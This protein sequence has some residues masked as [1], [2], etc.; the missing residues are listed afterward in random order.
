VRTKEILSLLYR[1]FLLE[2]K[3]KYAF[4]GLL[5]YVVSMVFVLSLAFG[6]SIPPKTWNIIFWITM[7]FVAINAV[8]KSFMSENRGITLYL[9]SLASPFSIIVAKWIYNCL[10]ML[11]FGFITYILFLFFS[12]VE[13][14]NAGHYLLVVGL[15]CPGFAT[16]L[17]LVSAIAASAENKATLLAI[18]SFPL[19]IPLLLTAISAGRKAIENQPVSDSASLILFLLLFIVIIATV[20]FILFPFLWRE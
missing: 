3:Q 7:L 20:S 14:G 19:T 11:A 18:L 12:P 2:W 1:E 8:A 15:A 13:T 17:T 10:L 4:N 16:A 9:Y 5:L 6:G